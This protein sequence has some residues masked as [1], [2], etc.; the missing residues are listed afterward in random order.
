MPRSGSF[1]V[2]DTVGAL[3]DGEDAGAGSR[4]GGVGV[5]SGVRGRADVPSG[6][7]S[8]GSGAVRSVSGTDAG[9]PANA[10]SGAPGTAQ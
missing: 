5:G 4:G 9:G 6:V 2:G 8:A 1:V 3:G 7:G 10:F